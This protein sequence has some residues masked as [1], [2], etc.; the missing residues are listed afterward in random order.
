[1]IRK[2]K[3][4]I[5]E[6]ATGERLNRYGNKRTSS[7]KSQRATIAAFIAGRFSLSEYLKHRTNRKV[8]QR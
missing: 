7:F 3:R 6:A 2:I 4:N 1:M 5:A 8:A